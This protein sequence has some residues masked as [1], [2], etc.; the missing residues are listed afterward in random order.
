LQNPPYSHKRDGPSGR[1]RPTGPQT[2]AGAICQM[3]GS[4]GSGPRRRIPI[5]SSTD[6]TADLCGSGEPFALMVLGES[7]EPEFREGDI[8]I[9]EP[10][11]LARDGSYVLAEV[12]GEFIFRRLQLRAPGWCL[13]ALQ[14]GYPEI[15]LADLD[16]VRGI[17]IQKSRPGRRRETR[18]YVE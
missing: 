8:V 4:Q 18:R 15:A 9:I 6:D 17:V 14:P 12:G 13:H 16:C 7:M 3:S 11:G 5:Q 1:R 10:E 2:R